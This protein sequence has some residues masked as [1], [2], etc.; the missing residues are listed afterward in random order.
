MV[1]T[2]N[3]TELGRA[4]DLAD[5]LFWLNRKMGRGDRAGAIQSARR[6][7]DLL[8]PAGLLDPLEDEEEITLRELV[9]GL[10]A[11]TKLGYTRDAA[12]E[13]YEIALRRLGRHET[14][15]YRPG[16]AK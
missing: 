4:R 9:E 5:A 14:R 15:L 6:C 13:A 2:T 12:R 16:G 3:P 7:E 10:A 1:K 11:G 8:G